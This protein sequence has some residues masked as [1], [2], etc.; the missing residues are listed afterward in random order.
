MLYQ[1]MKKED[2]LLVDHFSFPWK[3]KLIIA[4]PCT[5]SSYEELFEIAAEL[6]KR[7]V[8]FLRAGAYK[9]RTNPYHFQGLGDEGMNILFRIRDELGM[10]IVTE[11]TTI[12][13]IRKYGSLV[14]IIQI[15]ARNMYNYELL[16]E[17]GKLHTPVLL[18]RAFSATYEEWFLAAEYILKEGNS[19]VILCERGIRNFFSDETRNI[20]DIQAIPYVQKNSAFRILGDPSHASG[21]AYMV[22]SMSRALLA[23]GADGLL[24]EVHTHPEESLCDS[25]QTIDF[26]QLDEI[27]QF[28]QKNKK[29]L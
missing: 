10:H 16:K 20:L 1:E 24:I 22:S 3:D 15:G 6:K 9:L 13:Q 23:A 4:G 27:L 26:H 29:D 28:Y 11:F 19:N 14:D 12:E 5:F 21:E 8:S 7:G 25:K 17:A 2:R 18:K